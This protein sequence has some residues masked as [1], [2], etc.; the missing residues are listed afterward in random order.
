MDT[1]T[2]INYPILADF[3]HDHTIKRALR[4]YARINEYQRK[5]RAKKQLERQSEITGA[6]KI[7]R[8]VEPLI[9]LNNPLGLHPLSA[10]EVS[11]ELQGPKFGGVFYLDR[12]IDGGG[13]TQTQ[14]RNLITG[15][16]I[17]FDPEK[18]YIYNYGDLDGPYLNTGTHWVASYGPHYFDSFGQRPDYPIED[19]ILEDYDDSIYS[20]VIIQD[21]EA[22]SCGYYCIAWIRYMLENIGNDVVYDDF[23]NNFIQE[24]TFKNDL[25]LY[26]FL[27]R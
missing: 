6:G 24:P 11:N 15:L 26:D 13:K 19:L 1:E 14:V 18:A 16:D 21:P 9:R 10:S 25:I 12:S 4:S 17:R 20:D 23:M 27:A 7:S 5:Y 22:V 8:K 2:T 3:I